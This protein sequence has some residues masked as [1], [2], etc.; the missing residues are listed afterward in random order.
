MT[1]DMSGG[2]ETVV[3]YILCDNKISN[4]SANTVS[5]STNA[6]GA[7]Q[8]PSGSNVIYVRPSIDSTNV[9]IVPQDRQNMIAKQDRMGTIP[10]H[11][12]YAKSFGQYISQNLTGSG[13]AETTN[14]QA[15]HNGKIYF[16]SPDGSM[17]QAQSIPNVISS[18]AKQPQP[19]VMP[20]IFSYF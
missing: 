19:T 9:R 1:A 17:R 6:F 13:V 16:V 8:L 5:T 20:G 15:S 14:V 2:K 4:A 7:N 11:T 3:Q 10:T 12:V 18:E